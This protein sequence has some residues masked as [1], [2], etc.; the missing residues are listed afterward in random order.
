MDPGLGTD[1]FFRH[2]VLCN[3][4]CETLGRHE[5]FLRSAVGVASAM[6]PHN[7]SKRPMKSYVHHSQGGRWT[8]T[9]TRAQAICTQRR[10]YLPES[11]QTGRRMSARN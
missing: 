2:R 7:L 8:L 9:L 1:V 10:V 4:M 6:A 5:D 11:K 3:C